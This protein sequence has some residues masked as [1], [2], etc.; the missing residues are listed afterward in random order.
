MSSSPVICIESRRIVLNYT[1]KKRPTAD[2]GSSSCFLSFYNV[3]AQS[4]SKIKRRH[5]VLWSKE[6]RHLQAKPC[7][8]QCLPHTSNATISHQPKGKIPKSIRV[9]YAPL[10]IQPKTVNRSECEEVLV[11]GRKSIHR[12]SNYRRVDK[13]KSQSQNAANNVCT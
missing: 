3:P 6:N 11:K 5:I 4:E 1:V 9:P 2:A 10:C 8:H 13:P 7:S 12:V